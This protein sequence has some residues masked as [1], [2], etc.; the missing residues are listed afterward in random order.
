MA[1]APG[2]HTLQLSNPEQGIDETYRV[3]IRSGETVT[4]RLGL[5]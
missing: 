4:R 2:T 5:R 3:T 1:R